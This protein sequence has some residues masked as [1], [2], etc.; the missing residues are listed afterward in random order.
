MPISAVP[1]DTASSTYGPDTM[2]PAEGLD[3]ETVV[4]DFGDVTRLQ[5]YSQPP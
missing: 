5:K 4:G 3:L 1:F 2:S